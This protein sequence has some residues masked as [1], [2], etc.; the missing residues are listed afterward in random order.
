[1]AVP[2]AITDLSTTLAS[3]PPAGGDLVGTSLDDYLRAAYGFIA[4][5]HAGADMVFTPTGTGAVATTVQAKL[6]QFPTVDDNAAIVA[7]GTT[8]N[9]AAILSAVVNSGK[10]FHIIQPNTKYDRATLLAEATFPDDVVL[11]D[12]SGINDFTAAGESTKHFGIVSK[13]AATDDTHWSIDS[14]HH[15]VLNTNNYGTA[16]TTS[17]TNRL[18][19]WLWSVGQFVLGATDKRGFRGAAIQQFAKGSGSFWT[20]GIRLIAPWLSIAGQYEEWAQGQVISG[21]GVYRVNGSYHY[22]STG[23]GTTGATAPTHST[24]T[25]SDGGVSWTWVDSADRSIINID[26]YGRVILGNAAAGPTWQ[27][28]VS[29]TDPAG[30]Y[31]FKGASA[32]VSKTALL[33]L[34]PTDAGAAESPQPYLLA[35]DGVGLRVMNSGGTTD[36]GY[37]SDSGGFTSRETASVFTT[38][39]DGDTTPTVAGVGTLYL[40]N[41]GATSITALDDGGDGQLVDLVFGNANTTM[42]SSSTLLMGGSTNVTPTAWSVIRMKKVPSTISNRWIEISRSIK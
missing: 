39:A 7:D 14:G 38:A 12:F 32:G 8:D 35:Q 13:D 30:E 28:K 9:T 24:G 20:W 34:V 15:A 21:A 16:G 17:A 3:N 41:T 18:A 31:S 33:R 22:V 40:L 42:V 11:L 36:L 10:K 27:H 29:T 23:A 37:F 19:S 26:E 2:T 1:M 4:Q 5:L 25:V 6:R